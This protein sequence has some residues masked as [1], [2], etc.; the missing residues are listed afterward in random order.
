MG[1]QRDEAVAGLGRDRLD[2][3]ARSV[4]ELDLDVRIL[5]ALRDLPVEALDE[6]VV[7]PGDARCPE[8]AQNRLSPGSP[9][10]PT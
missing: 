5:G 2:D 9:A 3:D 6:V 4:G 7:G 1:P 10:A 8:R